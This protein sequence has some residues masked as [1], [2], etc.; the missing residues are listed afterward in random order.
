MVRLEEAQKPNLEQLRLRRQALYCMFHKLLGR[1]HSGYDTLND[2]KGSHLVA[3]TDR[4]SSQKL[5]CSVSSQIG[6]HAFIDANLSSSIA[7]CKNR[8]L[9]MVSRGRIFVNL[10]SLVSFVLS[11]K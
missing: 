4:L 1:D 6:Y 9:S 8:L 11:E 10:S 2:R 7:Y 3:K 5:F